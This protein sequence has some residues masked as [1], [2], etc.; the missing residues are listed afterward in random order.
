MAEKKPEAKFRAGSVTATVWNNEGIGKDGMPKAFSSVA[1]DKSY[2]DK[3]GVWKTTKSLYVQ[4]IPKAMLVLS[5]AYE[6]LA[7]REFVDDESAV[8]EGAV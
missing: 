4:D 2:K 3:D 7:L 8:A 5:K 1:F 6:H